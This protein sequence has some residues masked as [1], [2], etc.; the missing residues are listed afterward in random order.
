M[1][2]DIVVQA[3]LNAKFQMEITRK[4]QSKLSSLCP[5]RYSNYQSRFMPVLTIYNLQT[6]TL[7]KSNIYKRILP[8]KNFMKFRLELTKFS[9]NI[10]EYNIQEYMP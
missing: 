9:N 4:F 1:L 5:A 6:Y 10:Q 8:L 3:K 7:R 2:E